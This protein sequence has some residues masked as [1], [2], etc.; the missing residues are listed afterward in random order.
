M[1]DF[2]HATDADRARAETRAKADGWKR[3]G[4]RYVHT[5]GRWYLARDLGGDWI[6]LC[7]NEGID[8]TLED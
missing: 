1:T 6:D 2:D 8:W 3:Q 5:S 4:F 7:D